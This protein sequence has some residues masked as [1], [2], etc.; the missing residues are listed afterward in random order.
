MKRLALI[1]TT[2]I[3]I[4]L[5]TFCK[6]TPV[7]DLAPPPPPPADCDTISVAY[8]TTIK[9]IIEGNCYRSCHNGSQST[10]GFLL[11]TY[12]QVKNEVL[13]GHLMERIEQGP[14]SIY[15]PMPY[16]T[17]KLTDCQIAQFQ[18]WIDLNFPQ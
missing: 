16:D 14:G 12:D 7:S 15:H 11:E 13:V 10:S 18:K 9:P 4:L 8:T 1:A 6:H 3:F 2:L 17:G 5:F